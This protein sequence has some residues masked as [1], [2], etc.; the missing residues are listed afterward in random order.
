MKNYD[1][2]MP[3]TTSIRWQLLPC[4]RNS[5]KVTQILKLLG[6][7]KDWYKNT[8]FNQNWAIGIVSKLYYSIQTNTDITSQTNISPIH[9]VSTNMNQVK[10]T[11]IAYYLLHLGHI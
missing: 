6:N 7:A 8:K 4:R 5:I 3:R 1:V 10:C 9:S 2:P 11:F